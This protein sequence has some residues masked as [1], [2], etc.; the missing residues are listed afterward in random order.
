MQWYTVGDTD[1]R[2]RF[3]HYNQ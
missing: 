3:W 2:Y 1:Y